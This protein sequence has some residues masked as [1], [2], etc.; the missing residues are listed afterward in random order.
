[1]ILKKYLYEL[2]VVEYQFSRILV[3]S[4][5]P[6]DAFEEYDHWFTNESSLCMWGMIGLFC[7]HLSDGDGLLLCSGRG[8]GA[9][10]GV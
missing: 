4:N 8:E 5:A 9:V 1:M 3:Y 10:A 6:F 2:C 7:I